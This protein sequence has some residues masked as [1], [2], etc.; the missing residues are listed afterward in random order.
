M[1]KQINPTIK[2]HLIRSAFYVILLLAVCVIPFALAQRNTGKQSSRKAA[3]TQKIAKPGITQRGMTAGPVAPPRQ[4]SP[5]QRTAPPSSGAAPSR[6]HAIDLSHYPTF[7][8]TSIRKLSEALPLRTSRGPAGLCNYT[9]TTGTDTIVPG[10]TDTGNHCDDCDTSV[11]LPFSF[12]LY[13]QTYNAVN[14]DSNGRLDF[15]CVNEPVGY[16]TQCLPANPNQC[17]Y[18]YTIYP[19]WQDMMTIADNPGC[20]SFPGGSCGIFTSVSGVAPNRIF[21]IE[22]RAVYFNDTS[23][24]VS[25]EARLYENDPNKRFD[26]IFGSVPTGGDHDY[27]S[28][29]QG[30]SGAFTQDFCD[31]NPP[32]AGSRTYTCPGGPTPT[33]TPGQCQFKAPIVNADCGTPANTLHDQLLA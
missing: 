30:P 23:V 25:F 14:V 7:P 3:T 10:D 32:A 20:A 6:A 9:F 21:N 16:Q 13:D 24:P 31:P 17:A 12:Q 15:V 27:V 18:D 19:V 11:A 29:V 22:W 28:G 33:P 2:A 4:L 8:N 1:K 5:R 26:I